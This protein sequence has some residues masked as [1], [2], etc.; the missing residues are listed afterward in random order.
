M[1]CSGGETA[2]LQKCVYGMDGMSKKIR[3]NIGNQSAEAE[4]MEFT[5]IDEQWSRYRLEDG[6]IVKIK[7]VASEVFKLPQPDPITGLP[8]LIVRSSNVMSV[9]PP[10]RPLSKKEVQ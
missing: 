7:I 6:T 4:S 3:I 1:I 10:D 9:E 5:P 2:T 8:Q